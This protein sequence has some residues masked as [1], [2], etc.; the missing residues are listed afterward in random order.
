MKEKLNQLKEQLK[1][2]WENS[3]KKQKIIFFSVSGVLIA[4]IAIITI[5]TS[6]TKYVPIYSN[7][8]LEEVGQIKE[9]LESR[10]IPYELEDGGTT[11]KV[12]VDT[13]YQILLYLAGEGIPHY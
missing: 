11:I 4:L 10:N 13:I 8:S 1:L 2:L 3:T 6:T 12:P 5:F 7:L 9:E